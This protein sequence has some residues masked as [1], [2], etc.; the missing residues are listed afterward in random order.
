MSTAM[1]TCAAPEATSPAPQPVPSSRTDAFLLYGTFTLLLLGPLAFGAVEAWSIF[2]LEVSA[3][4][5]LLLWTIQQIRTGELHITL[6]PL[7]APMIAFAALVLI[8]VLARTTAYRFQPPSQLQLY[9]AYGA[10]CFLVTQLLR[11]TSQVRWL[12][13]VLSCYGFAVA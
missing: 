8:Q 5:L 3:A 2:L 11:R 12:T 4:A 7:F 9:A 6:N 13:V 1:A 10:I